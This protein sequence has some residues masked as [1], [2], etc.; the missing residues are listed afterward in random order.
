MHPH[1]YRWLP[2]LI[3]LMTLFALTIGALTLRNL[4]G[5]LVANTG[6]SL[7]FAAADIANKLDLLLGERCADV[8]TLARGPVF[9]G[10]DRTAMT[11]YLLSF[12]ETQPG[13]FWAGVTDAQGRITLFNRAQPLSAHLA[14]HAARDRDALVGAVEWLLRHEMIV[15]IS[16]CVCVCACLRV[17]R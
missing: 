1:E 6:E 17:L 3:A 4:E 9:W 12:L 14:Q 5:R 2:G 15:H 11:R 8:L 7:A 13:Y 10:Q 16:T